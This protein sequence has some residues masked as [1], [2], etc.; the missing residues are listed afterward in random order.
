MKNIFRSTYLIAVL[1][2]GGFFASC[3]LQDH[4]TPEPLRITTDSVRYNNGWNFGVR[5]Y[6]MADLPVTEH[7]ILYLAFFRA[8]NDHDYVPRIEHGG[9]IKFDGPLVPGANKSLYTGDAFAGRYFYFYR[10]YAILS[11]GSVVYGDIKNYTF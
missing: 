3:S 7:G 9:R 4:V 6:E 11:D 2:I 10:A 8:S 1:V 5:A